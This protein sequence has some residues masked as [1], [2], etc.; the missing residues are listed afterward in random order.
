MME[1]VGAT[2]GNLLF[3]K[4]W[5]NRSWVSE[6]VTLCGLQVLSGG[7]TSTVVETEVIG[8][9]RWPAASSWVGF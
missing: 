8:K 3:G 9:I 6:A 4:M 5:L 1:R 7:W 2:V